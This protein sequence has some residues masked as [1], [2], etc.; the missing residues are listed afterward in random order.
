MSTIFRTFRILP[1]AAA[2]GLATIFAPLA[3]AQ[4]IV[5][6]GHVGGEGDLLANPYWAFTE[7]F[8]SIVKTQT[9]GRYEVHVLPN[10]QL[11][12]LESLL[13]QNMRGS[14]QIVGELNAG[15]VGADAPAAQVLEM[16]YTFPTTKIACDVLDGPFGDKLSDTIAQHG[17]VRSLSYLPSAFRNFSN[18]VRPIRTPEDMVR[19]Q[20]A[21]RRLG[22]A[23]A[24]SAVHAHSGR[25]GRRPGASGSS[26]S[27]T[28]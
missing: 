24:C 5:R 14:P 1:A 20:I 3:D 22:A 17:R 7:V 2:L 12:D 9:N 10:G 21:D 27:S 8:G 19:L 18:S 15:H 11:G 26:W 25:N 16:A 13:E 6:F 23:A 28:S 4:T